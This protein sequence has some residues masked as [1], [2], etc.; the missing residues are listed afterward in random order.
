MKQGSEGIRHHLVL[1]L[2]IRSLLIFTI[3]SGLFLKEHCLKVGH[4]LG[5]SNLRKL[6]DYRGLL[7]FSHGIS[8]GEM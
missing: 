4:I 5:V 6:G 8:C 3:G 7:R 2:S 1:D